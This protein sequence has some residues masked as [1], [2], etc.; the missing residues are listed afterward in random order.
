MNIRNY[1]LYWRR[2]SVGLLVT[3][4]CSFA[5]QALAKLPGLTLIAIWS[6]P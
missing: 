5:G 6:W 3:L 4:A 1:S 2:A